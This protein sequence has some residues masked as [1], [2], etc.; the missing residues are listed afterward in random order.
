M[1]AL[2][3][4]RQLTKDQIIDLYLELAPYGGNLEGIRA[5]SIAYFG[6]EPKRLTLAESAL[7]V[8]LP[9]SPETRRLDRYPDAARVARDRVLDRMVEEGQVSAEDAA[10]AKAV[11]VPR[12]RKPMPI[13]APHSADQ[14]IATVKDGAP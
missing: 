14:A 2:Q 11:P 5:A 8:A 1:R 3:I 7:L 4:E 13:L 6:K 10:R 9:Q 12:L